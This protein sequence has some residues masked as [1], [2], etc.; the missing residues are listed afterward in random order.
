MKKGFREC[1]LV[2]YL[3]ILFLGCQE[4][5]YLANNSYI[6]TNAI[7]FSDC[8]SN[9]ETRSD[10]PPYGNYLGKTS[11]HSVG[12]GFIR[13]EHENMAFCCAQ[14]SIKPIASVKDGIVVVNEIEF[15]PSADCICL[16]DWSYEI[17]PLPQGKFSVVLL[18]DGDELLNFKVC[19]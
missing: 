2:S 9:I 4:T 3:S 15:G 16:Y 13:I 5:E 19:L 7:K 8:K 10:N 17:G 11:Y 14:D 18:R 1:L 12:N 6:Y